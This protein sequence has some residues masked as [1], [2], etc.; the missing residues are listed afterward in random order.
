[1]LHAGGKFGGSGYKVS[2]GLHGVGVSVVNAL[3][4]RLDARDRPRRQAAPRWRSSTAATPT[5]PLE[6]TGPAP[7]GRTGTTVTFWPDADDLR[8]DV[9]FRAQTVTERLQMMAFLNRGL[10][11]RFSDERR[12][13]EHEETFRYTGGIEDFVRHLNESKEPLFRKVAYFE[14]SE[15]DQEVEVALQW[16]TGYYESIHSFANGI[17]TIEGGMH[18]EG[19][20]KGA[21]ERRQPVRPRAAT[22]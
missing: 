16:N 1:M 12:G 15:P 19:F 7:R 2:G 4:T 22:C 10:E 17:A 20:K 9:E 5:G 21:H 6:V 8:R 18:E 11:I 3:S 13:H 14:Q